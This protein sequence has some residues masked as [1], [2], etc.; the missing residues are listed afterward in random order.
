MRPWD[1]WA[2]LN[3]GA[4]LEIRYQTFFPLRRKYIITLLCTCTDQLLTVQL[5]TVKTLWMH[6][7]E[8]DKSDEFQLFGVNSN[9]IPG[10]AVTDSG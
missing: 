7:A 3:H 6:D 8:W 5:V 10:L 9:H 1:W 2:A 4:K